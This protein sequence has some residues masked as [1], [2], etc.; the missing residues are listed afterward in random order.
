MR[1]TVELSLACGDYDILLPL[2]EGRVRPDG[3]DVVPVTHMDSTTRHWRFL[4]NQE[5]DAAELSLSSYLLARDAGAAIEALPVFPHRRFRHGFIFVN[6]GKGIRAPAD[7]IGRKVGV[8][9]FQ[10]SAILWMRGILEHEYGAPHK[11]MRWFSEIDEDVEF[12]PPPDLDL[13]R[14]PEGSSVEDMVATGELDALLHPDLIE[15]VRRKDPRVAP[16]AWYNAYWDEQMELLGPDPWAYGL[17]PQNVKTLET[18]IGYSYEQGLIKRRLGLDELFLNVSP[19]RRRG[20]H[21]I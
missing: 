9:S 7:L 5:F 3:V 10:V 8:K 2:I 17:T 13:T 6:A 20:L 16:L 11:A 19:G 21:R 4:R 14:L 15:P 18:A 12:E 1:K